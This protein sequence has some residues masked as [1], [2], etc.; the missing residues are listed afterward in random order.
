MHLHRLTNRVLPLYVW[1]GTAADGEVLGNHPKVIIPALV[2]SHRL[3]L[4]MLEGERSDIVGK[5]VFGEDFRGH[6]LRILLILNIAHY[7]A[8]QDV[9]GLSCVRV[10]FR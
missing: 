8:M 7:H 3:P 4:Q 10:R 2:V 6:F 5:L 9:I 1:H